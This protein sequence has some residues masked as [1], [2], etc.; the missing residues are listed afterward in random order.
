MHLSSLMK[1]IYFLLYAPKDRK[2]RL[3]SFGLEAFFV[4]RNYQDLLT[5]ETTFNK[6]DKDEEN[7][8]IHILDT[9][10]PDDISYDIGANI[11]IFTVLMAKKV[12]QTGRVIAFEPETENYNALQN[13]IIING[14]SNVTLEKVALG[15]RYDKANLYIKKRMGSGSISLI[16]SDD[17]DYCGTVNIV[18]GDSVIQKDNLPVPKVVKI[19]VEGFEYPVIKGMQKTLSNEKCK[20]VCCEI[21]SNL[22]PP[23]IKPQ[24]I[25]DLLLSMGF[26]KVKTYSRGKEI[27]A[28]CLKQ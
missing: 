23:E 17:S 14:L 11:G 22:C 24:M 15:D 9:L 13:N 5:F 2:I 3:Q 19:D 25:L 1:R 6:G 20:L 7:M 18:P 21:H 12:S 10:K 16:K 28:V 26:N 27:H 4:T 8:L